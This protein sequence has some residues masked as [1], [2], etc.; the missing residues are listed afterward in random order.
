MP[1]GRKHLRR[2]RD[3]PIFAPIVG[4]S[5][6]IRDPWDGPFKELLPILVEREGKSTYLRIRCNRAGPGTICVGNP[7]I[8]ACTKLDPTLV[9]SNA[10]RPS[11]LASSLQ[12]K[13][14]RTLLPFASRRGE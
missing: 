9:N 6:V 13:I 10:W 4:G 8:I 14:P 12:T 11:R 2:N 7:Y 5:P 3:A 1:L